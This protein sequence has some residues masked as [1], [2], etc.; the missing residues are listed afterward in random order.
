MLQ[1]IPTDKKGKPLKFGQVVE[2]EILNGMGPPKFVFGR[3]MCFVGS[4][5]SFVLSDEKGGYTVENST[6][7][8]KID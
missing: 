1:K 5:K 7:E 4:D 2:A 3:I 8:V 6:I